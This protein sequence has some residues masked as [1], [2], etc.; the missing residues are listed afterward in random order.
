MKRAAKLFVLSGLSAVILLSISCHST[1]LDQQEQ[2]KPE[3]L[4][5][6]DLASIVNYFTNPHYVAV[7]PFYR[8]RT[9]DEK[10]KEADLIVLGTATAFGDERVAITN[11]SGGSQPPLLL[12]GTNWI[13]PKPAA[14]GVSLYER[15]LRIDISEVLWPPSATQTNVITFPYYILKSWPESCWNYLNTGLASIA[16][17]ACEC[18][19]HG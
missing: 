15:D 11:F 5:T 16:W 8:R 9:L 1:R 3:E 14:S 10:V 4:N 19:R 18:M 7:F 13:F 12:D 17:T 6:N 2:V